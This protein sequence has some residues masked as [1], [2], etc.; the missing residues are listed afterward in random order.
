MVKAHEVKEG[1]VEV[2]NV[3]FVFDGGKAEFVSRTV[4]KAAFDSTSGKVNQMR[5]LLKWYLDGE[6]CAPER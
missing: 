5:A 3:D 1:G 6:R 2:V 4:G